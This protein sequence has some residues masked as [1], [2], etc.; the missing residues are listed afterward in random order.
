MRK[1]AIIIFLLTTHIQADEGVFQR[2]EGE[3]ARYDGRI[4]NVPLVEFN[5]QYFPDVDIMLRED[6]TWSLDHIGGE[7][8]PSIINPMPLKVITRQPDDDFNFQAIA[9]ISVFE[10]GCAT[11]V[12]LPQRLVS[13]NMIL[14]ET[15]RMVDIVDI[16]E[17]LSEGCR[18]GFIGKI[19]EIDTILDTEEL[20]S[21]TYTVKYRDQTDEFFLPPF[22]FRNSR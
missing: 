15:V 10:G 2:F 11:V 1:L 12:V 5:G 14:L 22:S 13:N 17:G 18:G 4:L 6:G 8:V 16:P 19:S 3:I 20:S 21:G 9:R 7:Q